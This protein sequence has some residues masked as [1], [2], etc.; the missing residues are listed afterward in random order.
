MT[1]LAHFLSWF[2]GF[3]ENVEN[4]P[5][6]SQWERIKAK[7]ADITDDEPAS[8]APSQASKRR[9]P[10]PIK[11][12]TRSQ[13]IGAYKAAMMEQGIDYESASEIL[14]GREIDIAMDPVAA[15]MQDK[16]KAFG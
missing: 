3:A 4:S 11:I 14:N 16:A 13:W 1:T 7:I 2:E 8:A 12:E 15:A 10:V 6:A 9:A 5:T